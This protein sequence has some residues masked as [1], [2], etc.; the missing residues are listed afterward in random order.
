MRFP[1]LKNP[2]RRGQRQVVAF[3]GVNYGMGYQD[4]ELRDSLGVSSS[5]FPALTT[6]RQ[7]RKVETFDDPTAL[8]AADALCVCDGTDFI[9]NGEVVGQVS[10]GEKYFASIGTRVLI[11]PDKAYFDTASMEFGSLEATYEAEAGAISFTTST[12]TTTGEAFPFRVGDAVEISGCVDLPENNKTSIIREMGPKSL[13]FYDNTLQAGEESGTVTIRRRVPDLQMICEHD[14][15]I[16]GVAD[17]TIY[18]SALGDPF[19]FFRY[20]GLSTD[21]F[22]VAVG[23]KGEFTGCASYGS[24]LCFFKEDV[25]HKMYGN[26]PSNY[27]LSAHDVPGVQ[28]GSGKS[29]LVIN[30]A[31]YYKGRLGVYVYTGAVPDLIS[32]NFGLRRFRGAVAGSDGEKYYL[33]MQ[34]ADTGVWEI[35]TYDLLRGIWLRLI[36]SRARDFAVLDGTLY[37]IRDDAIYAVN[38]EG[39]PVPPPEGEMVVWMAE[40]APFT[41]TVNDRKGYSRLSARVDLEAGSWLRIEVRTDNGPWRQV[42]R[43]HNERAKTLVVPIQPVRCDSFSVRLSGKGRFVL[44]SLTR[45]FYVGSDR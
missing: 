8:F 34:R 2:G 10:A 37:F 23:T 21:S 20:D 4:G 9:Y 24:Q 42:Y 7:H 11:C 6:R 31:L 33:S 26:K 40:L 35:Y 16:W 41:E 19:N 17:Q 44:R 12:V 29:L 38:Q 5:L 25:L 30:E 18:G 22:S 43:T 13:T 27:T 15:R 3:G 1:Q 32:D 45:D 14:N 28:R 39:D 36:D